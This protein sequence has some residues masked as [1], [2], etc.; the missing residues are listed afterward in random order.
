MLI[1]ARSSSKFRLR[2]G[3]RSSSFLLL[4]GRDVPLCRRRELVGTRVGRLHHGD[5][6]V[7][8]LANQLAS[9]I[10]QP[11]SRFQ[12]PGASDDVGNAI[13]IL[14]HRVD[15]TLPGAAICPCTVH[16]IGIARDGTP[17]P[18]ASPRDGLRKDR[19]HLLEETVSAPVTVI[20]G[21]MAFFFSLE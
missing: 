20:L 4:R 10:E 21:E 5:D 8:R 17:R 9:G 6:L 7:L 15:R 2:R 13:R 1:K 12:S 14:R 18:R 16:V 19:V 11:L 3:K